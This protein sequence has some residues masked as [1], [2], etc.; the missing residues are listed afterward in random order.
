MA[1]AMS[2]LWPPLPLPLSAQLA[3]GLSGDLPSPRP[4]PP[5]E[6]KPQP[7]QLALLNRQ[8]LPADLMEL[9]LNEQVVDE[10]A[11]RCRIPACLR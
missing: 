7:D 8:Q 4:R 5:G 10:D 9:D 6:S 3:R 11:R 2:F 1:L